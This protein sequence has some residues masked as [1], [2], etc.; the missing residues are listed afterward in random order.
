M[1]NSERESAGN[2]TSAKQI[3]ANRVN[4]RS[5]SGP[6]SKDGKDRS[7]R[8]SEKHGVY[9]SKLRPILF[10]PFAEDKR[11]FAA[12]SESLT[13]ALGPR[14]FVE[15]T[16]AEQI[17]LCYKQI[18]RLEIYETAAIE[19]TSQLNGQSVVRL[20]GPTIEDH[21]A[22]LRQLADFLQRYVSGEE[23]EWVRPDD[24][25][26]WVEFL[27]VFELD[28][29][30]VVP[31]LFAEDLKPAD[32]SGWR[33]VLDAI[34]TSHVSSQDVLI[35]KYTN[36]ADMLDLQIR[37]SSIDVRGRTANQIL[38]IMLKQTSV[39]RTRLGRELE[40]HIGLFNEL[41]ARFLPSDSHL[42]DDEEG[43]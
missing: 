25:Q 20:S 31:D 13:Q 35:D 24:Y 21:V 37:A 27:Y 6:R 9:S 30:L 15:W 8:N 32:P 17:V 19:G 22:E 43:L 2:G 16:E 7:S 28:E 29:D 18:S 1:S 3:R 10:G 39:L 14:D 23:N 26:R 38:D 11:N 12:W 42:P 5:S 4:A 40:R 33:Q 41:R 36:K 34:L